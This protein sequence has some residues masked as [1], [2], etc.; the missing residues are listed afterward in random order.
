M[1]SMRVFLPN[2]NPLE[3]RRGVWAIAI[4]YLA[5]SAVMW[6]DFDGETRLK[7]SGDGTSWY[8]PSVGFYEHGRFVNHDTPDT[9][10][11]YRPPMYPLF[12]AGAFFLAGDTDTN[13][14]AVLQILLLLAV[15]F[16]FRSIVNDW[17]A[18]WGT[19]GMALLLFNPNVLTIAQYVQSDTLFL[20]FV[21]VVLFAV[22]KY[23]R[24]QVDW[25]YP[26]LVGLALGLACLTRPTAQFLIVVLP[27][28]YPLIDLANQEFGRWRLGLL[29]GLAAMAV[30]FLVLLPWA[31][32]V[33]KI[34]GGYDLSSAEVKSRYI[35]DQVAMVEAQ[36]SGVSY[37]EASK[38]EVAK[39]G[40]VED[41]H[42]ERWNKMNVSERHAAILREGYQTLLSYPANS[43]VVAYTRSIL[44][45]LGAGGSGRW[46]YLVEEDPDRLANAW[47][48]SSQSDILGM[49]ARFTGGASIAGA[50]ASIGCI[51]FVV[52][53]RI[54]GLVGLGAMIWRRHWSLLLVVVA[55]ISY[56]ALIHLFVG[57]SRY[58]LAVEPALVLLFL[59]GI[60]AVWRRFR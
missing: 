4:L 29:K 33:K 23:A 47:F 16:L 18:N 20:F 17:L 34:E 53:A 27:I 25:R 19:A 26:L 11:A 58:R 57:N 28:A 21:T 38:K 22:L 12:A 39:W 60:E 45:F 43:L 37:H 42:G 55:M 56:F 24:G 59:Y 1:N 5:V 13:A 30:S 52:I 49:L 50:L 7:Y 8:S 10:S 54:L 2:L 48:T 44:Q 14:V 15:G 6:T 35:W 51:A 36:H 41:R 9:P 46:H 32:H 3:S 40:L 31:H